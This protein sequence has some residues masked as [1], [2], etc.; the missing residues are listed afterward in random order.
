M[1]NKE[2]MFYGEES[3]Y[4]KWHYYGDFSYSSRYIDSYLAYFCPVDSRYIPYCLG[5]ARTN[6]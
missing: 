6:K 5:R 3:F 2:A 1:W 4:R